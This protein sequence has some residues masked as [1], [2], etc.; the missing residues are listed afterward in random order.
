M[1]LTFQQTYS[2]SKQDSLLAAK[3]VLE[4]ARLLNPLNTDH[5]ANL[6]R[7]HRR[8][9]DLYAADPA[10]RKT[11][12]EQSGAQYQIATM[13]SPNNAI[14]WNEWSTV[15]MSQADV[16]RSAEDTA[17]AAALIAD[18]RANLDHSL[19]LDQQFEQTYLIR[20]QLARSQGQ[21]D[22]ARRNYE[23]AMKSNPSGTD[24]WGGLSRHARGGGQLH[25]G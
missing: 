13:L 25:R 6:A 1:K 15:L 18:A 8:W 22:E 20:A 11:Q 17:G 4:N 14:L 10:V 3:T 19:E 16:A 9:A 21:I 7:L 24:A 12:L 23:L 2:L 5:S